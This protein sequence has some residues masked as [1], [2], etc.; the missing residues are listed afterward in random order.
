MSLSRE[1]EPPGGVVAAAATEAAVIGLV[2][3]LLEQV[4]PGRRARVRADSALD[5][6]LGLDSLGRVELLL[7]LQRRFGVTL[8]ERTAFAAETVR[9]LSS[10]LAEA[11]PEGAWTATRARAP[12][13]ALP[14]AVDALP[15][16]A[17]TLVE[18]L[19]WHAGRHGAR[20]HVR[21]DE[22]RATPTPLTYGQLLERASRVAAGLRARALGPHP[23]V[24]LMLPTSHEFFVAFFGV[25]LAGGIPVPIY[26]PFRLS[27]IVEHLRRQTLILRNAEA[28]LLVT[29]AETARLGRLLHLRVPTLAAVTTTDELGAA[30]P[31]LLPAIRPDDVAL[32]Q[33]TSG[34]TGDPK[35][36]VLTHANLLANIRAIGLQ[37]EVRST[38]T[39]VSWLP[40]YHDMGLIGAWLASLYH[41]CPLVVMPSSAFLTRPERWLWAIHE[42]RGTLSAA[43][44]FGYELCASRVDDVRLAGLD[45]SSWRIAFNGSE[46]VS[47]GTIQR[48]TRRFSPYGFHAT[49]M[50]PVYGLAEGALGVTFPPAGRGP[51]IDRV[52]REAFGR[53]GRALLAAGDDALSFVSSGLPLPGHDV[54]VIDPQGHE[55]PER[56]EGRI[57]FRG[58]SAT[59]GY[60]RH[61]A[62]NQALFEGTWLET[63]D[64]GYFAQGELFVTGRAKDII[65]RAGRHL[66]PYDL[67]QTVGAIVGVR[68][69]GVAAF[70]VPDEAL[71]TERLV[72]VAETPERDAGARADLR[73]RIAAATA[74]VLGA[75]AEEVVLVPPRTLPKTSSGKL[76]RD[77]CRIL[78]RRGELAR[79][80][81][82]RRQML[83]LVAGA[84]APFGRRVLRWLGEHAYAAYFWALFAL[85]APVAF[86]TAVAPPTLSTRRRLVGQTIRAFFRAVG[87]RP[88]ISGLDH[89]PAGPHIV[90]ANHTSY[91]DGLALAAL[92]PPRYAFVVK[93]E[94]RD[95]PFTRLALARLG[96]ELVERGDAERGAADVNRLERVLGG[97]QALVFFPEGTLRRAHGIFPFRMGA[98]LVASRTGAPV[99][100]VAISGTR[101]VLL[102]DQWFPRRGRI[103]AVVLPA[104]AKASDTWEAAVGLRDEASRVLAR[105]TGE[106]EVS[107]GPA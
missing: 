13:E 45:L 46:P 60:L 31:G 89:L 43:P 90:V 73:E 87:A 32:V 11:R 10:A 40:L 56:T 93:A 24:A 39:V 28:R 58:P 27:Q 15:F 69:G 8:P 35:G 3:E 86:V 70:A 6:D 82:V 92:L 99:V 53:D 94:L 50:T 16:E 25:L 59:R 55:V 44:N 83:R 17:G 101:T 72:I 42:H 75:A 20:V 100:P 57:Q 52:D 26:P 102:G 21:L 12:A 33:Y 62:A 95:N 91:L 7:R 65:I 18:V 98:F 22:G 106:A 66:Y 47:P 81:S 29:T 88:A 38:D 19:A 48:F 85:L 80:P 63:G 51:H 64:L 34:S 103:W 30:P 41:A 67:E 49:A 1:V 4:Q 14:S 78:Y 76:R 68:K 79:A 54:R 9:D 37:A 5:R 107:E 2:R 74:G 23:A 71:G 36:V 77:T 84:I 61:P 104:L 96:A 97:G 105:A